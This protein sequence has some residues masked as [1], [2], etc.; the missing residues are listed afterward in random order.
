ML[1]ASSHSL[2][3]AVFAGGEWK[4]HACNF[5]KA[6]TVFVAEIFSDTC[7]GI[8]QHKCLPSLAPSNSFIL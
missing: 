2:F 1:F 4:M 7:K 5:V 6:G 3:T 8:K